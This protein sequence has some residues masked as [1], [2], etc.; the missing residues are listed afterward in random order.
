MVLHLMVRLPELGGNSIKVCL[1]ATQSWPCDLLLQAAVRG[2]VDLIRDAETSHT[3]QYWFAIYPLLH[4]QT[5]LVG[6]ESYIVP[7]NNV[8][9]L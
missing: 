7:N 5:V 9:N 1:A 4:F 3:S 6:L 8:C 2:R